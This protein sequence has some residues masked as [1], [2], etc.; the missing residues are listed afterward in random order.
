[1]GDLQN[2]CYIVTFICNNYKKMFKLLLQLQ[3]MSF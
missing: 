3:H 1:M 2:N